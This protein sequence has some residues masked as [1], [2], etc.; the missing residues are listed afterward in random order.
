[1]NNIAERHPFNI[2]GVALSFWNSRGKSNQ[3]FLEVIEGTF[4]G[5]TSR[6][7]GPTRHRCSEASI[8]GKP[9][10]EVAPKAG[11]LKTTAR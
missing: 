2:L 8:Y 4:P 5:K 3:A 10:F 7:Q 1:M 6:F 11:P 9:I